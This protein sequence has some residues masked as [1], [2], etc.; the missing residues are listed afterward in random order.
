ME[1][2]T[3]ITRAAYAFGVNSGR[4]VPSQ[5][6]AVPRRVEADSRSVLVGVPDHQ[7]LGGVD[8]SHVLVRERAQGPV[9]LVQPPQPR[10]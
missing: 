3:L 9:E 6:A 10:P 1:L 4:I 5:A 2:I 7:R 8:E